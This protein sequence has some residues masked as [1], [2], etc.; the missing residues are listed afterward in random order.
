MSSLV[1]G[2]DLTFTIREV[3]GVI[4]VALIPKIKDKESNFQ[5]KPFNIKGN[6]EE[7]DNEFFILIE[8]ALKE[9]PELLTNIELF[10]SFAQRQKKAA[11]DKAR[12][13]KDA[14]KAPEKK[15][16]QPGLF[17]SNSKQADEKEDVL[18]E[19]EE[20]ESEEENE[21]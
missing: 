19:T 17:D 20:G 13:K 8:K 4:S 11:E 10:E 1:Q 3:N 21:E 2:M 5:L 15:Q 6:V 7:L 18:E 16:S 12:G 9:V 14:A